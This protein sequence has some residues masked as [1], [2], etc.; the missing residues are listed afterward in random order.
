MK[1]A[2]ES[3]LPPAVTDSI[4]S[5]APPPQNGGTLPPGWERCGERSYRGPAGEC[6]CSISQAWRVNDNFP[7]GRDSSCSVSPAEAVRGNLAEVRGE[8][9]LGDEDSEPAFVPAAAAGGEAAGVKDDAAGGTAAA[10]GAQHSL[11][12]S[13]LPPGWSRKIN[14]GKKRSYP[15]YHG[16]DGERTES[17]RQAWAV[18]GG[19][20]PAK[21][22][23]GA[24]PAARERRPGGSEAWDEAT[25]A[26][27]ARLA[28]EALPPK[29]APLVGD[30]AFVYT[31]GALPCLAN[32]SQLAAALSAGLSPTLPASD[33]AAAAAVDC[34][35]GEEDADA[36][37]ETAAEMEGVGAGAEAE[38]GAGAEAEQTP[39][40]SP[41][42]AEEAE[43]DGAAEALVPEGAPPVP[44]LQLDVSRS[45]SRVLEG[46]AAGGD[47][48]GAVAGAEGCD[49]RSGGGGEAGDGGEEEGGRECKGKGS[50]E[51]E[52][53]GVTAVSAPK[54]S[55]PGP[56]R[57]PGGRSRRI[58]GQRGV[59][60][61]A[62]EEEEPQRDGGAAATPT[63]TSTAAAA[64]LPPPRR[65]RILVC[66]H[67]LTP[68]ESQQGGRQSGGT[69]WL[70]GP[71]APPASAA[72]Q[73][74]EV[75][76]SSRK[77]PPSKKKL[78]GGCGGTPQ[79]PPS[80]TE[81]LAPPPA[82]ASAGD[83]AEADGSD[84][85]D[86]SDGVARAA[87]LATLRLGVEALARELQEHG[88]LLSCAAA[89]PL[90]PTP[91]TDREGAYDALNCGADAIHAGLVAG[92][93][94]LVCCELLPS[95][96]RRLDRRA[97]PSAGAACGEGGRRA[98]GSS[99]GRRDESVSGDGVSSVSAA[100]GGGAGAG[101]ADCG[102]GGGGAHRSGDAP[103][104]ASARPPASGT[105]GAAL[106]STDAWA[107]ACAM[108]HAVRW[109][110]V[111]AAEALG[112]GGL[113]GAGSLR[114]LVRGYFPA[115]FSI[116]L[117]ELE[118]STQFGY[119]ACATVAFVRGKV[120]T[121]GGCDFELH[122]NSAAASH[123][124][125]LLALHQ[126]ARGRICFR[127]HAFVPRP[128]VAPWLLAAMRLASL[129]E[130]GDGVG[131]GRTVVTLARCS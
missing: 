38:A 7:G 16:P 55:P 23:S 119:Y 101:A 81:A 124:G 94:V 100:A 85:S 30:G 18:H 22:R 47:S 67:S 88:L 98:G 89:L 48:E 59:A 13:E 58:S 83:A 76:R 57:S 6:A 4:R 61:N 112:G 63:D 78:G 50:G 74:E 66:S 40:R 46:G 107:R 10:A 8:F 53:K 33:T 34:G 11:P 109:R 25:A 42:P 79:T 5:E 106:P 130:H 71:P 128:R 99:E 73:E 72:E 116:S 87:A 125:L 65:L 21:K 115:L 121:F 95:V 52:G 28:V 93:A 17:I 24:R 60:A 19:E 39:L 90:G 120:A 29:R 32:A 123:E 117:F 14:E 36:G 122:L 113:S 62:P 82:A 35:G 97:Q 31:L 104:A 118:R 75:R 51:G 68:K 102:G 43:A 26:A 54:P 84:G 2:R 64:P 96:V 45:T 27:A 111:P 20:P 92:D 70:V 44:E 131:G 129:L 69:E 127:E 1:Q 126:A 77:S 9:T 91:L 114:G 103:D 12:P 15:T 37:E 80:E 3:M 108:A 56:G 86:S 105:D 110:G 41:S 49:I